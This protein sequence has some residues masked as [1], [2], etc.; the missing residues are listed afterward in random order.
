MPWFYLK[1]STQLIVLMQYLKRFAL[2][3]NKKFKSC[4]ANEA[5]ES[6]KEFFSC[7]FKK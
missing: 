6:D 7:F 4:L 5:I 1:K 2:T 3:N